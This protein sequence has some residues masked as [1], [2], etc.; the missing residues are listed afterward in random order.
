MMAVPGR[1][2]ER[3]DRIVQSTETKQRHGIR[4]TDSDAIGPRPRSAIECRVHS[5]ALLLRRHRR[6]CLSLTEAT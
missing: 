1:A 2:N 3:T 5:L 4:P 6:E